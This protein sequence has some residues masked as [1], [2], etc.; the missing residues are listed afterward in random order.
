MPR[1]YSSICE[2][3]FFC[4]VFCIC[5]RQMVKCANNTDYRTIV[6][7]HSHSIN[8]DATALDISTAINR[9]LSFYF[10]D[11]RTRKPIYIYMYYIRVSGSF[12]F[13]LLL[14]VVTCCHKV[15]RVVCNLCRCLCYAKNETS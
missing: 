5:F 8:G 7:V 3:D 4:F 6:L 14:Y 11:F 15:F 9:L 1:T 13:V 2:N 12:F 10:I